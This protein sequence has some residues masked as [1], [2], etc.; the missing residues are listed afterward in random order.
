MTLKQAVALASVVLM[1]SFTGC[2]SDAGK[3]EESKKRDMN[4]QQ[5][6]PQQLPPSGHTPK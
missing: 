5:P 1:T 4:T 2:A 3:T 6:V